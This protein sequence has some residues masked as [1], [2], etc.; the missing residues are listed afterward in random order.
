MT[1]IGATIISTS[2]K[3][4]GDE[5]VR[6]FKKHTGLPVKV[7]RCR[8]SSAFEA[9]LNLDNL[10]QRGPVVF[11]D[12]DLWIIRPWEVTF[13]PDF[14]AVHDP[15]VFHGCETA[16]PA[17][18]CETLGLDKHRY[19]N[20]GLMVMDFSQRAHRQVFQ[21]ARRSWKR[22]QAGRTKAIDTTDQAHINV[23]IQK[24]NPPQAMLPTVLNTYLRAVEWGVLPFIPR[25]IVGLHAAGIKRGKLSHL[26]MAEKLFSGDCHP[27]QQEAVN[28]QHGKTFDWR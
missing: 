28:F 11:F 15:M 27:M 16:F 2:Y 22:L 26:T 17:R 24:V 25:G 6:R 7:I 20:S 14:G 19:V 12:A 5:A 8:D 13:G 23:G 4:L 9:K 3:R 1:P 21:H 10:T 18:D